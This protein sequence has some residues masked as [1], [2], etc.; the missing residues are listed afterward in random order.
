MDVNEAEELADWD[1]RFWQQIPH[2]LDCLP[3]GLAE[4]MRRRVLELPVALTGSDV[5]VKCGGSRAKA[6]RLYRY[7][8]YFSIDV[9]P[10][11]AV[12]R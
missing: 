10:R 1:E 2:C 9:T 6:I 12:S 11:G 8:T 4:Q 5:C 3:A 7:I